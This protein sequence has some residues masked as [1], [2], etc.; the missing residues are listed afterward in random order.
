MAQE[1]NF[2]Q[3]ELTL[4]ELSINLMLTKCPQHYPQVTI[5]LLFRFGIDQ[6]IIDE[7]HKKLVKVLHK[8]LIHEIHEVS[9]GI[10]QPK[11]HHR[12]LIVTIPSLKCGLWNI[13]FS[14]LQLMITRSKV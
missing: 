6:N 9:R 11:R 5:M 2:F 13:R 1:G 4:A 3:P 14:N 12:V 10:G 7:H 8:D